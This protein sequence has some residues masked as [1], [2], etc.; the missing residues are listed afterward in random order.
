[1]GFRD[2]FR[3]LFGQDKDG[4]K[5]LEEEIIDKPAEIDKN[6]SLKI[7][8]STGNFRY[9]YDLIQSGA[10]EVILDRDIILD[11]DEKSEFFRGIRIDTDGIVIDGAGHSIDTRREERFFVCKGNNVTLKNITFKNGFKSMAG[12]ICNKGSLTIT[13]CMFE[14]CAAYEGGAI[15]NEGELLVSR[16]K[17]L[18][19]KAEPNGIDFRG[20][21]G[22][23]FND[24]K[25]KVIDTMFDDNTS[26]AGGAIFNRKGEAEI[27]TSLFTNFTVIKTPTNK[28]GAAIYNS[29]GKLTVNESKF[30][31]YCAADDFFGV[32]GIMTND[33]GGMEVSEATFSDMTSDGHAVAVVNIYGSVSVVKSA[34]LDNSLRYLMHLESHDTRSTITG[35]RFLKNRARDI[36]VNRGPLTIAASIFKDNECESVLD[37]IKTSLAVKSKF[38]ENRVEKAA[39]F[40]RQN[41]CTLDECELGGNVSLEGEVKNILNEG[42]MTLKNTEIAEMEKTIF[43]EDYIYIKDSPKGLE[44]KITGK[45]KVE[46]DE[47]PDGDVFGFEF[48]DAEI[49]GG[50][51]KEI[52]LTEDICIQP[53]ENDFYEGGIELDIDGLV[54][55]GAGKTIDADGKSRI[56]IVT[57]K[58]II[59]KNIVFRNGRCFS[60]GMRSISNGGVNNNGGAVRVNFAG[61]NLT[62]DNCIFL[63]NRADE[64]GG[65]I[66]NNHARQLK[67]CDCEF[68][69]NSAGV[70]GGAINT[71]MGQMTIEDSNF[72]SNNGMYGG[73]INE[74]KGELHISGSEFWGNSAKYGGVGYLRYSDVAMKNT[75][76]RKNT[77]LYENTHSLA[78]INSNLSIDKDSCTMDCD[79]SYATSD[80]YIYEFM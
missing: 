37:D 74:Y 8:K 10:D 3:G 56:F 19:S 53:Y 20:Y 1:M 16:C 66:D 5:E 25:V 21:G 47:V 67:I 46:T 51:G 38:I 4:K 42:H 15:Y 31:G 64:N 80:P 39:I 60:N 69:G 43:N 63:D 41:Y 27:D 18:K 35:C 54:I 62:M 75:M 2:R 6:Q 32:C 61:C 12:A 49:H 40:N 58:D 29:G 34:F 52:V 57:G 14:G 72:I 70:F 79:V 24:G 30:S 22:A 71:R 55:D 28:G 77:A 68:E 45:G 50:G 26:V 44:S 33:H 65:A 11:E 48:L 78:S 59:L 76:I 17:F 9:L 23:I 36:I 73:A 13:D 7:E